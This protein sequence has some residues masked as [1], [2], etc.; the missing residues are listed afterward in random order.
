MAHVSDKQIAAVVLQNLVHKNCWV[1]GHTPI[2]HALG[3]IPSHDKKRAKKA[4]ERLIRLG[5]ILKYKT[6]H[7]I[8]L[9][10]NINCRSEITKF[11]LE[12]VL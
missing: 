5:W 10:L 9:H 7:G 11:I 2:E 8:D 1:K 12:N 3:G 6:A 4:V